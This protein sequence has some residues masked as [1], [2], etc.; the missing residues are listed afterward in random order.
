MSHT[1]NYQRCRVWFTQSCR[2]AT[3]VALLFAAPWCFAH[4]EE[5]HGVQEEA[6]E[7]VPQVLAPGYTALSFEAPAA[8]SYQLSKLGKAADAEVLKAD[9]STANLHDVLGQGVA[10]LSFIYTSCDDVNGCPL[11]TAVLRQVATRFAAESNL[12]VPLRLLSLSFDPINDTPDVMQAYADRVAV[13]GANWHFLTTPSEDALAPLLT[14]YDQSVQKVYDSENR[15]T[16]AFSHVL[17]V[18]LIDQQKQIR[19]IYSVS[20]LH[21]DTLVNDVKTL[22]LETQASVELAQVDTETLALPVGP[23]DDKTGYESTGYRTRSRDLNADYA[24]AADLVAFSSRAPLGLPQHVPGAHDE[25]MHERIALGRQ[26]F[27]D[28]RLSLNNTLSCAICHI[29]EQGFTSN[30]MATAVGIEGRSVRRNAPSLL[31]VRYMQRFFHDGREDSLVQQAW[32]PLLAPEEMG[33]PSVGYVINKVRSLADYSEQFEKVFGRGPSMETVGEALA[34]YQQ[35]LVAG[36]SAFDRWYYGDEDAALT[37]T[38]Q[39]GFAVFTGAGRCAACHTIAAD[40][41]LFTDH[42]LHNTGVGYAK[43]AQAAESA[44]R[45]MQ[46]APGVVIDLDPDAYAGITQKPASDLGL[47]EIT[48]T[49]RDRWKYRT[50][51]LRNV[52]LTAPYMHDGSLSSLRDVVEF[53]N[54]GGV[55]NEELDPLIEPLGLSEGDIDALVAFLEALTGT[56][57]DTLVADAL[58]VPVGDVVVEAKE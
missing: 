48:Q 6:A 19:N 30:E 35:A 11:A 50:P 49:P 31:N 27:F 1:Y 52:A 42:G 2:V 54:A 3:A 16:G 36:N 7:S 56:G 10:L 33:N 32:S 47:Y 38:E 57:I 53:Y 14:A 12:G 40:H 58:A 18:F 13:R 37:P 29:P 23:G 8:G 17:R 24:R 25:Q 45:R 21:A 43:V 55:P 15:Y 22:A 4:G 9:G 34:S 5:D 28:R 44:K 20:F 41:A 51:T 39:R 46:I 26:L